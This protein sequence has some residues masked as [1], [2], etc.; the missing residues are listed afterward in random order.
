M[1]IRFLDDH[2]EGGEINFL[3]EERDRP[4][5]LLIMLNL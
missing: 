5:D 4:R 2:G 1:G 3:I